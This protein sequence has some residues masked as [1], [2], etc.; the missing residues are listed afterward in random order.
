MPNCHYNVPSR[1]ED[2]NHTLDI[3]WERASHASDRGPGRS[4][5]ADWANLRG[6]LILRITTTASN[7]PSA[8]RIEESVKSRIAVESKNE[9]A[10]KTRA[11]PKDRILP[12]GLATRS[13]NQDDPRFI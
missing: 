8:K 2:E 4:I 7:S 5:G 12:T 11:Q 1:D 10:R 9:V 13:Q 6:V 3:G